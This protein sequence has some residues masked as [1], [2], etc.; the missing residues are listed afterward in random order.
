MYFK[1]K[2]LWNK[3][4]IYLYDLIS[5]G[6]RIGVVIGGC[7]LHYPMGLLQILWTGSAPISLKITGTVLDLML[8]IGH[9]LYRGQGEAG[10]V[11]VMSISGGQDRTTISTSTVDIQEHYEY[12]HEWHD[13]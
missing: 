4:V 2:L 5:T 10:L 9:L 7:L 1:Y 6:L 11:V 12:V 3:F 13:S 8:L